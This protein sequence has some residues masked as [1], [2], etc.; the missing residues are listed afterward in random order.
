MGI[1]RTNLDSLRERY[2]VTDTLNISNGEI[3]EENTQPSLSYWVEKGK[4]IQLLNNHRLTY[5]KLQTVKLE[6]QI[7]SQASE[8]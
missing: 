1:T 8:N 2:G 3:R 6:Q 7:K 4:F 5:S